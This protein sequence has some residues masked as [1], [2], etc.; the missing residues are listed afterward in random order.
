[1]ITTRERLKD[2]IQELVDSFSVF[3]TVLSLVNHNTNRHIF[4]AKIILAVQ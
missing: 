4:I 1:M 3:V 2:G